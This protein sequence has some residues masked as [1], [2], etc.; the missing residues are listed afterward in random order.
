LCCEA[1]VIYQMI[2]DSSPESILQEF[3]FFVSMGGTNVSE[4]LDLV[5]KD[6]RSRNNGLSSIC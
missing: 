3:G 6:K 5:I 4:A 1:A 2:I